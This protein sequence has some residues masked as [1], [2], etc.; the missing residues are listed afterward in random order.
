MSVTTLDGDETVDLA[1]RWRGS[2]VFAPAKGNERIEIEGLRLSAMELDLSYGS[3]R[4]ATNDAASADIERTLTRR[5][6]RALCAWLRSFARE[7]FRACT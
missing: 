4:V 1:E 5:R 6:S 3:K 7:I 2:L